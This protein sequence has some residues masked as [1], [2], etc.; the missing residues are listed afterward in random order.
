MLVVPDF[1]FWIGFVAL[2]VVATE[3]TRRAVKNRKRLIAV[4]QAV[5]AIGFAVFPFVV[6]AFTYHAVVVVDDDGKLRAERMLTIGE[7]EHDPNWV[8]AN[9]PTWILNQSSKSVWLVL[10]QTTPV[11]IPPDEIK[12][13]SVLV[14]ERIDHI[15]PERPPVPKAGQSI[16]WL[17]W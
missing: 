16:L 3:L 5:L 15:G 7:P 1:V 8:Y 2:L 10:V 4:P 6:Q 12:P 13:G 17:K 11:V 14:D 9:N